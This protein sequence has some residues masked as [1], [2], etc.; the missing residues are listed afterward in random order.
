MTPEIYANQKM[1][2]L[3]IASLL[4]RCVIHLFLYNTFLSV[5]LTKLCTRINHSKEMNSKCHILWRCIDYLSLFIFCLVRF[6]TNLQFVR[7][8]HFLMIRRL[9]L[10]CLLSKFSNFSSHSM[11]WHHL[12]IITILFEKKSWLFGW[13]I[14]TLYQVTHANDRSEQ[15]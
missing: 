15:N 6:T 14:H 8:C 12:T 7:C 9:V 3:L 5:C 4:S 1:S 13:I 11:Q 10:L 2:L